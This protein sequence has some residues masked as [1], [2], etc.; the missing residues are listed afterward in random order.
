M[1]N[2]FFR[3]TLISFA[4][5]GSVFVLKLILSVVITKDWNKPNITALKCEQKN[6]VSNIDVEGNNF[7]FWDTEINDN[8][9]VKEITFKENELGIKSYAMIKKANKS[10][11][12]YISKSPSINID[13]QN[14]LKKCFANDTFEVFDNAEFK[15]Q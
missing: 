4:I 2:K 13:E 5:L 7:V 1:N 14:I 6:L 12:V 10:N 3:I 9:K 11:I 8:L 15:K